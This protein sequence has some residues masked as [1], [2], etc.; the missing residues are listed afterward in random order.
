MT[1]QLFLFI[2]FFGL[3]TIHGQ[4]QKRVFI[5]DPE[6]TFSYNLPKG[7]INQDDPFYHFIIL[8]SV[9]ERTAPVV[10]LTYYEAFNISLADYMDGVI[11][12]KLAT[13]LTDFK[14]I[15]SGTDF[16][17]TNRASWAKYSFSEEGI[18]KCGLLY[19]FERFNQYFEILATSECPDFAGN[20]ATFRK[21]IRSLEIRK[22]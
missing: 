18:A 5:E 3:F 9:P 1:K 7:A 4:C 16:V 15:S 20:E 8:P 12:G 10:Q 14:K 21:I 19:S 13:S 6:L 17:D 22:N 11:N 2:G